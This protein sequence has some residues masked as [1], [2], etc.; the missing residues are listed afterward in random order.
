MNYKKVVLL[1]CALRIKTVYIF[2]HSNWDVIINKAC[3][4]SQEKMLQKCYRQNVAFYTKNFNLSNLWYQN[5]LETYGR[6]LRKRSWCIS[7]CIRAW[8]FTKR[9]T[10]SPVFIILRNFWK[11]MTFESSF[12]TAWDDCFWCISISHYSNFFQLLFLV[13]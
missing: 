9:R 1:L 3:E 7:F 13:M 2:Y 8:N 11:C 12:W 10:L 5:V 4:L 6:F